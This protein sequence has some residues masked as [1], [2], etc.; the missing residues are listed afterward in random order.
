MIMNNM[1][2]RKFKKLIPSLVSIV[3]IAGMAI[4][5][6]ATNVDFA[7]FVNK[8]D[9]FTKYYDY[10]WR[11]KEID[12]MIE[13]LYKF[14]C[15]NVVSYGGAGTAAE[16]VVAPFSANNYTQTYHW[17]TRP[18]A[19][20][21][22]EGYLRVNP[23]DAINAFGNHSKAL[24]MEF[25]IPASRLKWR[26]GVELYPHTKVIHKIT[27]TWPNTTSATVQVP[28]TYELIMGPFKKFPYFTTT[29]WTNSGIFAT[30]SEYFGTALSY[31]MYYAVNKPTQPTSWTSMTGVFSTVTYSRSRTD[32]IVDFQFDPGTVDEMV[33]YSYVNKYKY[34][35]AIA[36]A[37]YMT[38]AMNTNLSTYDNVWIRGYGT[39]TNVI[40]SSINL[41]SYTIKGWNNK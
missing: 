38:T 20:L 40:D 17:Y 2:N 28:E 24:T 19:D 26:N 41:G 37:I 21:S 35:R 9:F 32:M 10:E 22:E 34:P 25:E 1:I 11:I 14:T 15:T 18:I 36:E 27:R 6:F 16:V 5:S 31:N 30:D 4:Q 33:E 39:T 3:L 7:A 13:R 12:N 8:D 23:S 29:G